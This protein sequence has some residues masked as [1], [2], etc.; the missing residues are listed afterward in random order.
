MNFKQNDNK[1]QPQSWERM[2]NMVRN[3]P[4]HG[5]YY[6]MELHTFYVGLNDISISFID[7]ATSGTFMTIIQGNAS[8][9]FDNMLTNY[10]Q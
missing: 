9:L 7:Q 10:A 5:L 6:W 4:T 8:K 1:H 2:K 3:C